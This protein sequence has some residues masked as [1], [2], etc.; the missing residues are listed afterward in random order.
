MV[1]VTF[2]PPVR[3]VK[4]HPTC[5]DAL[6]QAPSRAI[7]HASPRTFNGGCSINS[8]ADPAHAT[9]SVTLV[10]VE[11]ATA[12]R[13]PRRP[14]HLGRVGAVIA[15][16]LAVLLLLPSEDAAP[17]QVLADGE[18]PPPVADGLLPW[19]GRGPWSSDPTFVTEAATAWRDAARS[20]PAVEA[21][22][23]DV[24]PLWAG[25]V[26][27]AR[28][29]V[30]QSLGPD[31]VVLVAQVSDMLY[32]WLQP[33]LR[34]LATARV[35]SEP[36]F[37]SFPFVGPDDRRGQLDP[38]VLATFQMLPGPRVSSG[39]LKV[40]RVVGSRLAPVGMQ[41]DGLSEPW[42]YGR[43]W[44]RQDPE[45]AV[46][47]RGDDGSF[48]SAV[49]LDPDALPPAP[50]PVALVEPI[51]GADLP[52]EPEDYI[53]AS[54]AMQS[55]GA[56]T[57][58]AAVLGSAAT[59]AGGAS[60]VQIEPTGSSRPSAVVVLAGAETVE[61]SPARPLDLGA[62]VAVGAVRTADGD[63]VVVAAASPQASLLTIDADAD[64]VTTG[65]RT[66]A[67]VI[68]SDAD[69]SVVQA[70]VFRGEEIPLARASLEVSDLEGR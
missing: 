21:P 63:I 26:L 36:E 37:F 66:Q 1:A 54:A 5:G 25:P 50:P 34:L 14:P 64:V 29:A 23:D 19:P 56:S 47:T 61:V 35:D 57:G 33:E 9:A 49:R 24:V 18:I 15:A 44:Q 8:A 10:D 55:L 41:E 31:G 39:E 42:A 43:W 30:L 62:Q 7:C 6:A 45:I 59:Q 20:D 70:R 27:D 11:D 53:V 17:P 51:W 69:V 16:A 58:E 4:G 48:V 3:V 32:G 52:P 38:D 13:P 65:G 67:T 2:P 40:L 12:A 46:L 22:G 60:L 28:M 68:P